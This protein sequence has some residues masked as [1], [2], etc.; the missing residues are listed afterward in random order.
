MALFHHAPQAKAEKSLGDGARLI[1]SS[2]AQ[3]PAPRHHG[4]RL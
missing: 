4:P 3:P 2:R 1:W